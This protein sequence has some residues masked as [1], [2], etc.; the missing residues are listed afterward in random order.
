MEPWFSPQ[1]CNSYGQH[2]A[3]KKFLAKWLRFLDLVE[4]KPGELVHLIEE[5]RLE[6]EELECE[7]EHSKVPK[8]RVC[9][10]KVVSL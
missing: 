10:T 2:P 6:L 9:T 4:E 8:V 1:A 3:A 5:R 7:D